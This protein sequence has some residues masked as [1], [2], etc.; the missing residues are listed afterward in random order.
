VFRGKVVPN[1]QEL[2]Y[3]QKA[4]HGDHDA[5]RHLVLA[6][7]TPVLTYLQS[8]LGDRENA[9]DLAQ[10][11]FIAA[12]YALPHWQPPEP[13]NY[14]QPVPQKSGQSARSIMDHPLAP[15]LYRI[16]TNHALTFLKRQSKRAEVP[17]SIE[18]HTDASQIGESV[19]MPQSSVETWENRYVARELLH[20]A[21][22]QLSAD[23]AY[24][25]IL[26]FVAGERYAEIAERLGTTKE[27][28]RKRVAR[29]LV[30]LRS[31]Y[32][33]LDWEK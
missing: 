32:Q 26:R 14:R 23:D 25:I 2:E 4:A 7:E 30:V 5:F 19:G 22:S 15:W 9:R 21:L 1:N 29:G 18:Q 17:L 6:Y 27:A 16:A 20:E 12:F 11:T 8:I 3:I 24:C 33:A 13:L 31:I 28:V 10:E